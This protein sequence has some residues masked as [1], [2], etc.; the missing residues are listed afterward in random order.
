MLNCL[1]HSKVAKAVAAVAAVT[2]VYKIVSASKLA[3]ARAALKNL[4]PGVVHIFMYPRW[5]KGPNI[6]SPCLKLETF[7]RIA[8]IPYVAHLSMDANPLSPTERLPFISYNGQ[9][10]AE[11]EFIIQF[12]TEKF[13]VKIDGAL[14]PEK[15]AHGLAIRRQVETFAGWGM[16]RQLWVDNPHVISKIFIEEMGA[17]RFLVN[18]IIVPKYRKGAIHMLNTTGHGDLTDPQYISE[19]MRDLRSLELVLSKQSFLLTDSYPTSYDCSVFAYL[20]IM[21]VY[22]A[23]LQTEPFKFVQSSSVLQAYV[24]R[25]NKLAFPD[26]A[27]I[28]DPKAKIQTFKK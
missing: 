28:A 15:H 12:L 5:S 7:L 9:L 11:S 3:R 1:L 18:N 8:K 10:M 23:S 13:N 21:T 4:E 24:D 14:E 20:H 6:S 25:M 19:L 2:V 17:P 16:Y 22:C 27:A 26:M